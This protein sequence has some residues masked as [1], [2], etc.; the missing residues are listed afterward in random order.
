MRKRPG[1]L[2]LI[3]AAVALSLIGVTSTGCARELRDG[4]ISGASSFAADV[5][6][7]LLAE[8]LPFPLGNGTNN[9]PDDPFADDPLQM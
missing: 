4:F 8:L 1:R 9:A 3:A 7:G 5:T 2:S 6:Y